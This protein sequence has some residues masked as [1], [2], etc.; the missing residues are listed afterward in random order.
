MIPA[1]NIYIHVPYCAAKCRYCAFFSHACANPDWSTYAANICLEIRAWRDRMDRIS[2]PTVF[3]GGGTPSLM[4]TQI[5]EQIIKALR[6][7][8][9]IAS[10]AEITIEANPGTI[11]PDKLRDFVTIGL[12]RLSIG[13]QSLNDEEL[14]YLGRIHSA[15]DALKLID[16]ALKI[17]LR[18]SADFIYALPGWDKKNVR[19][20]CQQIND[21]GL[22]HCSL[23]EL[24]IERGTPLAQENPIMPDNDSMADMY[25]AIGETLALPRYEVSNYAA[26]GEECRHNVNVW[27]GEPYIGIGR[28]AA[29]RVLIDGTWHEQTGGPD[30]IC[31][32]ISDTTRAVER[33]IT[34]M[35]TTRGTRIDDITNRILAWEYIDAHPELVTRHGNRLRTTERGR[36]ILDDLLV[37]LVG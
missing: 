29:G 18:T 14:R 8:F 21:L 3:F 37:N 5:F 34:G 24:T 7:S 31:T 2:V 9:D 6:Q 30:G 15:H 19:S 26:P 11:G 13:V 35:R 25:N 4:P 10:N 33:I 22:R 27:D 32:P 23:Y 1:H 20:L 17:G 12:N 16:A 36:L 28:G